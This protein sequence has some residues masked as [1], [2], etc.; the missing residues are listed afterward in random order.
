MTPWAATVDPELPLPEYP[1]PQLM[2]KDWVNLNGKW[3]YAIRSKTDVGI[4]VEWDGKIL[5]PFAVE[6]PL[7]GVAKSVTD[8]EYLWYRRT[9]ERPDWSAK[10]Q[11]MLNFGAV[12]W[13]AV[14][15]VNG[16]EIGRHRGGY[17]PFSINITNALTASGP[18]EVVVRVWDSTGKD[19]EPRGKQTTNPGKIF[20]TSVSGIWQTVWL[21]SV[22][23]NAIERLKVEP[24]IDNDELQLTAVTPV[25]EDV[26]YVVSANGEEIAKGKG[27]SNE[28]ISISIPNA[29]H[30]SPE[31]PFLYDLEVRTAN[32]SVKSYFGMRKVSIG[33]D[34]EGIYRLYL[35][36][37]PLFQYG[38]LDQGYWPDGLYTA[39]TDDALRYDLEAA[40]EY[41]F[42]MVRKHVKVEPARWYYWADRLGLLVWQDQ[43]CILRDGRDMVRTKDADLD[44]PE[45]I[46]TNF[47]NEMKEM[48]DAL[49]MHPS[50]VVWIPFN[51]GWGQHDTNEVIQW[52]KQQDPTRLVDGPSG[53]VDR[54]EG[55][56]LDA[57]IYPG[58]TMYPSVPNRVSVLGEFGGI[59]YAIE[60]HSTY[61]L[62][63]FDHRRMSS[64]EALRGI[65]TQTLAELTQ[66]I[67][68]GL[69]AAIYTQLTDVEMETNG[70]L[71]YDRRIKKFPV[72]EMARIHRHVINGTFSIDRKT[73]VPTS[74]Q[75]PQ[76]WRY[77]FEQPPEGW[78]ELEFDDSGWQ[79][80]LGGFGTL[81]GE[82]KTVGTFWSKEDIWMRRTFKAMPIV[83]RAPQLLVQHDDDAEVYLNGKKVLELRGSVPEYIP[84]T[85]SEEARKALKE[86]E[87]V[88]AVHCRRRDEG[89]YI[90]VGMEEWK[91]PEEERFDPE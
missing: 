25:S 53:W 78:Q 90:D 16:K 39:P 47:R 61:G 86:G 41:G 19:G 64:L 48:M 68:K 70:F 14:V 28:K 10:D 30:W 89:Q 17:A 58:L 51:E 5:V 71:T 8:G 21:E 56:I 7:S 23:E 67:P 11:V 2:R 29:R 43:P 72:K 24:N 65:Y 38:I 46:K 40:K 49:Q 22:P 77:T 87:N 75:S 12:D 55:D 62:E 76:E 9:F 1:R 45:E 57:H 79:K 73:L 32:D 37:Q 42:N 20:Y 44:L 82:G 91:M 59:G 36:N 27:R 50:I 4:P 13:E 85:L 63:S 15:Y 31:D 69:S 83:L 74:L 81:R 33:K 54:G 26:D 6:A 80:G 35:N 52:V 34:A 18:Q 3:D 84:M 88:L 66:M 60:N